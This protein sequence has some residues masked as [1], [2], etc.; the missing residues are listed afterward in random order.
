MNIFEVV[1]E[2]E[3]CYQKR[4]VPLKTQN[5]LWFPTGWDFREMEGCSG[6]GSFDLAELLHQWTNAD[7]L[8]FDQLEDLL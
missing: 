8:Y 5:P 7:F 3:N 2:I 6:F 1:S 4:E